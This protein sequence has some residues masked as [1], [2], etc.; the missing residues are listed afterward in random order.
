MTGVMLLGHSHFGREKHVRKKLIEL[1]NGNIVWNYRV[2]DRFYLESGL[3]FALFFHFVGSEAFSG[4]TFF[5]PYLRPMLGTDRFR[6]GTR[7]MLGQ[8][9]RCRCHRDR[10]LL[11]RFTIRIH[12]LKMHLIEG[13]N[14]HVEQQNQD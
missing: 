5:G 3:R 1:L 12:F 4:G 10:Y 14:N 6:M 9:Q 11:K 2:S 8:V 13:E 7:L